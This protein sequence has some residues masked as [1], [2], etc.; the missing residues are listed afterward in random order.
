MQ[1]N[2]SKSPAIRILITGASR[3][4]GAA[5]VRH[6][7]AQGHSVAALARPSSALTRLCDE[8]ANSAGTVLPLA[9]DIRDI[10]AAQAAVATAAETFGGLDLVLNN[11]GV[12]DPIAHI[13]ETDADA[14]SQ[15]ISVNLSGAFAVLQA[16]VRVMA[17]QGA[18]TI[19]N[20][21]SGAAY[22]PMEGWSAYCASKAG[23]QM[24][25]RCADLE[26]RAAGLHILGLSPG[27]VATPMQTRIRESGINPVSQLPAE[28]H[29]PAQWVAQA[30]DYLYHH[31]QD[32]DL[33]QDFS[34]KTPE[35]RQR[36]D[37]PAP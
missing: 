34:L 33:G 11:A 6:F 27:T 10:D 30:V 13:A 28:A 5:V 24:L 26:Y 20:I 17:P 7:A 35:G 18:G 36:V 1:S 3:G 14:W 19:I 16:A 2:E 23:L 25:T 22:R 9:V 4:I 12:I 31:A 8:L 32:E 15:S 37:L 29:I 21:S